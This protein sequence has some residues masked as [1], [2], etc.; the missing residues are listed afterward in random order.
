MHSGRPPTY[1]SQERS[2]EFRLTLSR[3]TELDLPFAC[4]TLDRLIADLSEQGIG[5]RRSRIR[6]ILLV[7]GLKWRHGETWFG[8]RVNPDFLEKWARSRPTTRRHRPAAS[9]SAWTRW[10]RRR[11]KAIPSSG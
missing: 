2:T 4:W 1:S 6:E 8:D 10:A 7:E 3:P 9:S 11:A 5:M